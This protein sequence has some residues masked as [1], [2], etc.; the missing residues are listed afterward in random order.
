MKKSHLLT[1]AC[2][3]AAIA[4]PARADEFKGQLKQMSYWDLVRLDASTLDAKQRKT[5]EKMK[6]AREKD[7]A[8]AY[9]NTQ[10]VADPFKA[11]T[12]I[13][14]TAGLL[15]SP[16]KCTEEASCAVVLRR[17]LS[18][19]CPKAGFRMKPEYEFC[20]FQ[21]AYALGGTKLLIQRLNFD[22][23]SHNTTRTVGMPR[24]CLNCPDNRRQVYDTHFTYKEDY[25]I[26]VPLSLLRAT[27][28]KGDFAA[29]LTGSGGN[30][31]L[32]ITQ[33]DLIGFLR[34][35]DEYKATGR[36]Q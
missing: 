23:S 20:S 4:A 16:D 34:K 17:Q 3:V 13:A 32:T 5:F 9:Q 35:V 14:S 36:P 31:V 24:A 19:T 1:I 26:G 28:A 18:N 25:A 29:K 6:A 21:Q 22:V 8:R 7:V 27:S 11:E 10:V 15:M 30:T 2:A 12:T 33:K